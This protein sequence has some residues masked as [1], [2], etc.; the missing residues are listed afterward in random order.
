MGGFMPSMLPVHAMDYLISFKP[1][2]Q[3]KHLSENK[4]PVAWNHPAQHPNSDWPG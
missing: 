4:P 3:T 1:L 2:H